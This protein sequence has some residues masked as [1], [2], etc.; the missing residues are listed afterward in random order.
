M[1]PLE[2]AP[3][4]YLACK[5]QYDE[6]KTWAILD[7]DGNDTGSGGFADVYDFS[8]GVAVVKRGERFG[9]IRDTGEMLMEPCLLSAG[10]FSEGLAAVTDEE[11][12][13]GYI[14]TA[15]SWV[16]SD[17]AWN[18]VGEFGNGYALVRA[19]GWD[20]VEWYY[21]HETYKGADAPVLW[22]VIDAGGNYAMPLQA[23]EYVEYHPESL[24]VVAEE[25]GVRMI[26]K[27]TRDGLEQISAGYAEI[28]Y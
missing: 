13:H 7:A 20:M 2:T 28:N 1:I 16:C 26:F 18:Y 10:T 22:G 23:Y 21:N 5:I 4:T 8:E 27:I 11:Y 14:D 25:N 3:I 6:D 17:S 12:R 15:G 9:Y 19:G 24:T